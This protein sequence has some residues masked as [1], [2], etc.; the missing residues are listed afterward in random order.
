MED[1]RAFGVEILKAILKRIRRMRKLK[2]AGGDPMK[3]IAILFDEKSLDEVNSMM[4]SL[5]EMASYLDIDKDEVVSLL[6]GRK[7][8]SLRSDGTLRFLEEIRL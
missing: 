6:V 7:L 2:D 3:R 8:A 1:N 4:I 5:E